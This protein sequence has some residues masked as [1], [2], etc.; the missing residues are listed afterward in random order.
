MGGHVPWHDAAQQTSVAGMF[1]AGDTG[2]VEEA[3]SAMMTGKIAGLAAAR[4]LGKGP[5]LDEKID[6]AQ[7][8]LRQLRS[9]PTGEK[10]RTGLRHIA[11]SG[12]V[13]AC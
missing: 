4:Y 12:G 13:S 2:G 11:R 1:V 8:A 10:I 6:K 5:N 7:S 3:S 9:G